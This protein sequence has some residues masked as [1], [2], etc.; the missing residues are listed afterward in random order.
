MALG[1]TRWKLEV[2]FFTAPC[3]SLHCFFRFRPCPSLA[4][5]LIGGDGQESWSP[6]S[7][8]P[9]N[10]VSRDLSP[11]VTGV[12]TLFVQPSS[13]SYS[14][15]NKVEM[16][17]KKTANKWF[18]LDGQHASKITHQ[19]RVGAEV[20]CGRFVGLRP[21]SRNQ[22][23]RSQPGAG[24][25]LLQPLF[26]ILIPNECPMCCV[27]GNGHGLVALWPC[28]GIT[29]C[30]AEVYRSSLSWLAINRWQFMRLEHE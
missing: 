8:P 24:P 18:L 2:C 28:A 30:N 6:L 5:A 7:D 29:P 10:G 21:R 19:V 15:E 9:R 17:Q 1:L 27:W 3:T 22:R 23:A 20:K 25:R 13:P 11:S 12:L 14:T 26:A 16:N 4:L